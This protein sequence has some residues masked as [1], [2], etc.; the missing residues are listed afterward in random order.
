MSWMIGVS[1]PGSSWEFLSLP[2]CPDWLWGPPSLL[3]RKKWCKNTLRPNQKQC[4]WMKSGWL[5]R[6]ISYALLLHDCFVKT[7]NKVAFNIYLPSYN[8]ANYAKGI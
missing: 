3:S 8:L 4:S 5:C 2:P 6:K 7:Y 1:S